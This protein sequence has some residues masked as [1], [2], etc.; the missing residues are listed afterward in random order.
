MIIALLTIPFAIIAIA[1]AIVPLVVGMKYQRE[2][3]VLVAST[4]PATSVDASVE[5]PKLELAA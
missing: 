3:E 1:I 5:T 2:Y 4:P